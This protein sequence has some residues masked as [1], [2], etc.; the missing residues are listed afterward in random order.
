MS[1]AAS[2]RCSL[3]NS[4][5][6]AAASSRTSK[7]WERSR[8][9]IDVDW[10]TLCRVLARTFHILTAVFSKATPLRRESTCPLCSPSQRLVA[11]ASP[12]RLSPSEHHQLEP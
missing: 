1:Y 10:D 11:I 2:Q 5:K 7:G 8:H 4:F 3:Y 6:H 12:R 9:A